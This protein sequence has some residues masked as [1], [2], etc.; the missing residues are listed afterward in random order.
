MC[1]DNV[2]HHIIINGHFS[3]RG[4]FIGITHENELIHVY[5][6]QMDLVNIKF[7][8]EISFPLFSIAAIKSFDKLSGKSGEL[9]RKLILKTDG[10]TQ[11]FQRLTARAIFKDF[12]SLIRAY[13]NESALNM[14][15]NNELVAQHRQSAENAFIQFYNYLVSLNNH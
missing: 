14:N 4:N 10:T 2:T 1:S 5:K 13:A 11:R 15:F 12:Q 6:E 9:N 7:N 3:E 8:H